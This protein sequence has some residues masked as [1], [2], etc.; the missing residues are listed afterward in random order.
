MKSVRRGAGPPSTGAG[1]SAEDPRGANGCAHDHPSVAGWS[2]DLLD[3]K[4]AI[5]HRVDLGVNLPLIVAGS[6]AV[7]GAVV[8]GVGG[9]L[10]IVR[11]L[12]PAMLP[13][14]RFGGPESTRT[15]IHVAWHLTTVAFLSV[16]AA[17][18]LAGSV[19]HGD[20]ARGVGVV[21]AGA[22]TGFA[23]VTVG[24]SAAHARSLRSLLRHPAPAVL[25][26]TAV[27]GWWG[28]LLS[29]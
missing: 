5:A 21:G 3:H 13:P 26:A 25:T 12:S 9:E 18:L 24:L 14:S 20:Q 8:H 11:K 23:A 4:A 22:A 28:A 17:L 2:Q 15:M 19:L 7:I 10:L 27:L 29:R 1:E 16:G 6:L